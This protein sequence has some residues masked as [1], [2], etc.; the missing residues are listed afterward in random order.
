MWVIVHIWSG[1]ALG[2]GLTHPSINA[3]L[4][5]ILPLALLA[6]AALDLV[7]HWDYT[8]SD[9]VPFWAG[10]DA[11]LSLASLFIAYSYLGL[12]P[13]VLATGAVSAL[14]DLDVLDTVRPSGPGGRRWFPS[15]LKGFPHGECKAVYGIPLQVAVIVLSAAV[16]LL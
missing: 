15:H 6:H 10:A 2:V 5:L 7:P 14:P 1:L 4:W 16:T 13:A 8:K 9:G 3:P 12:P 11:A